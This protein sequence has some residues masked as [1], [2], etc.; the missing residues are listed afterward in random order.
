MP[1]LFQSA[2]DLVNQYVLP[3]LSWTLVFPLGTLILVLLF[4]FYY[5]H[6]QLPPGQPGSGLPCGSGGP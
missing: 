5:W 2:A 4:F 1:D 6:A 3:Y